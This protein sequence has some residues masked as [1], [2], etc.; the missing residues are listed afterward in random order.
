MSDPTVERFRALVAGRFRFLEGQGFR[1]S[2]ED[3]DVSPAG[4]SVVY[5]GRHVGFLISYDS[6]DAVVDVRVARVTGGR[7][8]GVGGGG[9]SRN[10]LTHLVEH[11]GY[12]GGTARKPPAEAGTGGDLARMV[13]WWAALLHAEGAALLADEPGSLPAG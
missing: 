7:L 13:E 8:P 1:R 11:A 9:Y 5:L 6:R 12:R 4:A 3:E 10:L 2:V